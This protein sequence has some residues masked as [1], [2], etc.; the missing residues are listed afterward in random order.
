MDA[1]RGAVLAGVGARTRVMR[2]DAGA[3][4]TEQPTQ[5]EAREGQERG[6]REGLPFFAGH[7]D[8]ASQLACS[9]TARQSSRRTAVFS[10]P[11]W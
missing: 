1:D 10:S 4:Q 7:G 11:A 6:T 3:A 2:V 5:P 8:P 9:G